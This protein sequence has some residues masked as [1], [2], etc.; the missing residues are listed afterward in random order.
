MCPG[1]VVG[2]RGATVSLQLCRPVH[3][4]HNVQDPNFAPWRAGTNASQRIWYVCHQ[5][6][7][8]TTATEKFQPLS[9]QSSTSP[10]LMPML[11]GIVESSMSCL[12]YSIDIL[13]AGGPV[14]RRRRSERPCRRLGTDSH[15]DTQQRIPNSCFHLSQASSEQAA[16]SN[17]HRFCCNPSDSL[18]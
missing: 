8:C 3:L 15:A 12:V 2:R 4:V 18:F 10:S 5:P 7:G 14:E 11:R 1:G 9:T 6:C 13:H 17:C 16:E